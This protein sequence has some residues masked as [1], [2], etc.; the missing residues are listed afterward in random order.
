MFIKEAVPVI[1]NNSRKEQTIKITLNTYKG[2]FSCSAPSGKS[3]GK[4]EV[5][6]YNPKGLL[7]SF[8][9]LKEFCHLLRHKNF[10]IKKIED[11]SKIDKYFNRFEEKRGILGGNVRYAL[12]GA[13]LKAGAN[14]GGKDL[15][16]F[17][18]DEIK[19][20]EKPKIPMPVGNCIGGGL[21]TDNGRKKKPDFQEFL[22]IPNEKNFSKAVTEMIHAYHYARRKLH[23]KRKNDESALITQKSNEEVLYTLLEI[24]EKYNMRIGTDVAASTFFKDGY[25][26]Y[27]NKRLQRDRLDQIDYIT[28]LIDK[29][30]LFYIEDPLDEEEF[31]GFKEVLSSVKKRDCLI[32]GDDLTTTNPRRLQRA[33]RSRSINAIII[34]PNQIGSLIEVKKVVEMCKKNEIK[35]IFSHRSGETMDTVLA[36]YA[37]GFGADFVKCGIMGSERLIKLKRII[38]IE[39]KLKNY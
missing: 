14:E 33:I 4:A 39:K 3:T 23:T 22:L 20:G 13:F 29:Y 31:N 2:T 36:D 12:H 15:W 9:L 8:E 21:H 32:V 19:D 5:S 34:K 17:I 18:N 26:H 6:A 16:E 37:L 30:H 24:A 10:M 1:I 27:K 11:L 7:K 25:Y 35:M 38:D 28:K